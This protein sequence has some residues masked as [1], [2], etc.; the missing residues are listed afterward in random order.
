MVPQPGL[1]ATASDRGQRDL[2]GIGLMS[3]RALA[4]W[5]TQAAFP[6]RNERIC[7]ST[8]VHEAEL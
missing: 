1:L 8:S 2:L 7:W 3:E 4:G 5:G 6:Y